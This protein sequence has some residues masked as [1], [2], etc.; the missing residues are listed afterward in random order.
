[1]D[2][3]TR[4]KELRELAQRLKARRLAE[5][6]LAWWAKAIADVH[7]RRQEVTNENHFLIRHG[8]RANVAYREELAHLLGPGFL[9]EAAEG[10]FV[11]GVDAR[12]FACTRVR[13]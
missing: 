2:V 6:D 1:M 7:P 10:L 3:L 9:V 8:P 12:K 11:T 5:K 4:T 13:W